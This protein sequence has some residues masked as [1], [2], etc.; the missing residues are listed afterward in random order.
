MYNIY[1]IQYDDFIMCE[2]YCI[3]L[4]KYMFAGKNFLDYIN[5]FSLNDDYKKKAKLIC[6]YFKGK[7]DEP[8]LFTKR[9]ISNK[10]LSFRTKYNNE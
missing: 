2:F 3:A 1:R 5:L 4:I 6:K 7:Y 10:K 9:N 8:V